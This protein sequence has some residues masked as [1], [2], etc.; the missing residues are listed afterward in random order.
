MTVRELIQKLLECN[1]EAE[2]E[3]DC[4]F[5][6]DLKSDE[7]LQLQELKFQGYRSHWCTFVLEKDV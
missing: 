4:A 5:K 1:L 7:G 6:D 3:F 2:I